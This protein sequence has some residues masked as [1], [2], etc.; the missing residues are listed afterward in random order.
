MFYTNLI[1]NKVPAELHIYQ[2]GGHGFGL[3]NKT[4]S[5]QWFERCKNWLKSNQWLPDK[6]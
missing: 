1:A 6:K 2:R 3:H 4:T 5:D